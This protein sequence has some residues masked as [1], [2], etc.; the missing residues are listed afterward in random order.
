MAIERRPEVQLFPGRVDNDRVFNVAHELEGAIRVLAEH[1]KPKAVEN[2]LG[3]QVSSFLAEFG[4]GE[5]LAVQ[6]PYWLVVETDEE[7]VNVS[8]LNIP[9][10]G[11]Q[12]Q[13]YVEAGDF[14]PAV[15]EGLMKAYKLL[16]EA[17]EGEVVII[18]SPTELYQEYGSINDV[19]NPFRVVKKR[20][21]G[22]RLVEG[23][24][25]LL[26]V[27][28]NYERAFLLNW[29]GDRAGI[30]AD[31]SPEEIVSSPQKFRLGERMLKK[32][33]P[34]AAHALFLNQRFKQQFG[35]DL[36]AGESDLSLY[37]EITEL[38]QANLS[39]LYNSLFLE[40]REESKFQFFSK[41]KEM[42]ID[43]QGFWAEVKGIDVKD[44]MRR[45]Y[46]GYLPIGA[47]HGGNVNNS[48]MTENVLTGEVVENVS[49]H[50]C[51]HL[52]S[53]VVVKNKVICTQCGAE[54]G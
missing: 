27:L 18:V 53:G 19:A 39:F 43:C 9:E 11:E 25:L 32:E 47:F 38:V 33:D 54:I 17:E 5:T 13:S 26:N 29:H 2:W 15:H 12:S 21:D 23:R 36:L 6:L 37:G 14:R 40:D 10:Y 45:F 50:K 8:V 52:V 22:S 24:Y 1:A 35:K 7:G 16:S 42:I 48:M 46:A 20:E 31:A 28:K 4:M 34:M 51:G 44:H 49:C 30:S 41:L 3:N